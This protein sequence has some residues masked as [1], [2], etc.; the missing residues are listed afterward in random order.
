MGRM[1]LVR[2]PRSSFAAV[3]FSSCQQCILCSEAVGCSYIFVQG[4]SSDSSQ[5]IL[6]VRPSEGVVEDVDRSM[7]DFF[8]LHDLDAEEPCRIVSLLDRVVQIFDVVV[9]FRARQSFGGLAVHRLDAAFGPEMP[10]DVD[11]APVLTKSIAAN[12]I[13][14]VVSTDLLVQG[15]RVHA[16]AVDVSQRLRYTAWADQVHQGVNAL[17][18]VDVVIPE[19]VVLRHVH[20]RMPFVAAVH[21]WE[22]DRVP[23]EENW[24]VVEDE[25]V[26]A[27]FREKLDRETSDVSYGVAGALFTTHCGD[28]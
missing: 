15:V 6:V 19:H 16:E 9:R 24:Q 20:L 25:I 3:F 17:R 13:Q 27:I 12:E 28:A 18:V 11:K 10:L 5:W 7:L 21:A 1:R 4:H 2:C 8:W 22:L 26:I 14:A 23:D